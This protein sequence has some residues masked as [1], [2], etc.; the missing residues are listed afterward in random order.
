MGNVQN[1]LKE[2]NYEIITDYRHSDSGMG[3]YD[4]ESRQRT[5][6]YRAICFAE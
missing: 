3:D 1:E 2:Q 5:G 4:A 6:R